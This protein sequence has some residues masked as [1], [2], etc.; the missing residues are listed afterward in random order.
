M[1]VTIRS[2]FVTICSLLVP[3]SCAA[4][5]RAARGLYPH[6]NLAGAAVTNREQIATN[7]EQ[8]VTNREQIVTNRE[9][10]ADEL[11]ELNSDIA[12]P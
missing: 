8:I 12:Q 9:Q 5:S 6:A 2:L 3:Q 4:R 1:F 7:R 11:S 10:I